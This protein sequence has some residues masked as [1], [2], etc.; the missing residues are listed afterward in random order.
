MAFFN[1]YAGYNKWILQKITVLLFSDKSKGKFEHTQ[2]FL[3]ICAK[4]Q[5]TSGVPHILRHTYQEVPFSS[6]YA[7]YRVVIPALRTWFHQLM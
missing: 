2:T 6:N 7:L 5:R 4:E 1:Q 3:F